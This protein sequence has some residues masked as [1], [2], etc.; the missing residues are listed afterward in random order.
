MTSVG[1]SIARLLE[2]AWRPEPSPLTADPSSLAKISPLLMKTGAGGLAWWRIRGSDLAA[3]S[4]GQEFQQTF[5]AQSLQSGIHER[6]LRDAV[7]NLRAAGIEPLLAK[8]WLAAGLYAQR[9]LRP[10]GDIDLWIRPDQGPA[11][12]EALGY[13]P[14]QQ[15]PIDLHANTPARDRTWDEL[16]G[17][18]HPVSVGDTHVQVLGAEDHLYLLS[19]HMLAHGAWRPLWLCDVAPALESMPEDFDWDYC[20]G[21]GKR[22]ANWVMTAIRLASDLLGASPRGL[23][24]SIA[25]ARLPRWLATTVLESWGVGTPY[26]HTSPV[27]LTAPRPGT[28]WNALRIRWPNPIQVTID[29]NRGFDR[30]PRLPVQFAECIVRSGRFLLGRQTATDPS[31]RV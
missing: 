31:L 1:C 26:M 29:W 8:G 14:G 30:T 23:P 17:R 18:S 24:T 4:T 25:N 12:F 16:M 13:P 27:G 22:R 19:V 5:R 10:Y 28:L 3:S 21:G 11:A 20:L 9:G 2:G 15:H 7:G 6:T